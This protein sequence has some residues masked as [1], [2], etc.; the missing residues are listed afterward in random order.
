MRT[1]NKVWRC[2]WNKKNFTPLDLCASIQN[3]VCYMTLLPHCFIGWRYV[4][5]DT[6]EVQNSRSAQAR[7]QLHVLR[8]KNGGDDAIYGGSCAL[9]RKVCRA[10]AQTL[11]SW[12]GIHLDLPTTNKQSFTGFVSTR[13]LMWS[14]IDP[15]SF[16]QW[17]KPTNSSVPLPDSVWGAQV[18]L[19]FGLL[20]N[21]LTLA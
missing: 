15:S 12:G 1:V 17:Q 6:T 9:H 10:A 21:L 7:W 8:V 20:A 16:T 19:F 4:G 3:H 2:W 13:L 14:K 5:G 18:Y 11:V